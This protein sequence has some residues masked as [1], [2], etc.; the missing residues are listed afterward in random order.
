MILYIRGDLKLD[1][2][3]TGCQLM[4]RPAGLGLEAL[5]F[6]KRSVVI[7]YGTFI[8]IIMCL[9]YTPQWISGYQLVRIQFVSLM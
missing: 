9:A 1:F 6:Q 2:I 3:L 5:L 8:I 4:R 7:R